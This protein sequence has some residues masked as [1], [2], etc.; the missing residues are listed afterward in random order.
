MGPDTGAIMVKKYTCRASGCSNRFEKTYNT[1]QVVC[2]I[3]CG[4]AYSSEVREKKN[5][6]QGKQNRKALREHNRRDVRWQH[7][8]TQKAF[9]RMRV[10]EEIGWFMARGREPG[11]ISCGKIHMDWACG[12]FKTVGAQSELRY[13]R[14]NTHLQCNRYCN[15][16]LSGNINGNKTTRGYLKGLVAR[17]GDE[18][19]RKIIDHCETDT[20]RKPWTWEVLESMRAEFNAQIRKMEE[21]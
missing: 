9:N 10:L 4:I 12:H 11:C 5:R 15:M 14:M 19:A 7:K 2:G 6:A 3:R 20:G 21:V 8:L 16:A 17:Y 18:Q 1:T 13:D